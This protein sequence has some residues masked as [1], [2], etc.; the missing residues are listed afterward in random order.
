MMRRNP[1]SGAAV[2][3]VAYPPGE[4]ADVRVGAERLQ[5]VVASPEVPVGERGVHVAV[6]WR[7]QGDGPTGVAP[8]QL[9][10]APLP[11]PHLP[12]ARA[13]QE[14]VAGEAVLADAPAAQLA[15]ALGVRVQ[16]LE[17]RCHPEI[18]RALSSAHQR[19]PAD[20]QI[21]GSNRRRRPCAG[22]R[23]LGEASISQALRLASRPYPGAATAR[24][25]PAASSP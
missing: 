14:M 12:G 24:R 1:R 20:A 21:T 22:K 25:R 16:A 3:L 15:P 13:R 8:L 4:P 17:A 11:A 23:W 5:G 7:A 19:I 9:A 18:I 10:P 6:A 2:G